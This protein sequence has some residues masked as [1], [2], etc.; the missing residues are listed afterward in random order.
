MYIWR[1][2]YKQEIKDNYECL[3]RKSKFFLAFS[4]NDWMRTKYSCQLPWWCCINWIIQECQENHKEFYHNSF[5][6]TFKT[7]E[8]ITHADIIPWNYSNW[9]HLDVLR[10]LSKCFKI[11][12]K[13]VPLSLFKKECALLNTSDI[14]TYCSNFSLFIMK[15]HDRF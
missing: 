1:H 13:E 2:L 5:R 12:N 9:L 6:N 3:P 11:I 14:A 7:E 15:K 10:M 4:L 8:K